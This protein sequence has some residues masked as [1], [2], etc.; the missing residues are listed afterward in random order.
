MYTKLEMEVIRTMARMETKQDELIKQFATHLR[1]HW[2][3]TLVIVSSTISLIVALIF[4]I[5]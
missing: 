2:T 1:H 3:A 4:M 5:L